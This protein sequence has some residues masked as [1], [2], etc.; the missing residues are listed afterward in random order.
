[1]RPTIRWQR[2]VGGWL[3][4]ACDAHVVELIFDPSTGEGT[5]TVQLRTPEMIQKIPG[6]KVQPGER[7][8]LVDGT[9]VIAVGQVV[10]SSPSTTM[11]S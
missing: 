4:G 10:K 8:E 7:F 11:D 5:A 3:V 1:M 2:D 9:R 6:G